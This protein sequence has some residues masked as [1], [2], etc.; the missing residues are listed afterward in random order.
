VIYFLPN[1]LE[2]NYR[3]IFDGRAAQGLFDRAI[4]A[5]V[6]DKFIPVSVDMTTPLGLIATRVE[7][8]VHS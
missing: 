5:G 8:P 2:G 3:F 4:A 6:I 1:S 7:S